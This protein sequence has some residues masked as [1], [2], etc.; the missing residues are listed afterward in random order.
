M[1]K[2]ELDNA[3]GEIPQP[4]RIM[5]PD[6]YVCENRYEFPEGMLLMKPEFKSYVEFTIRDSQAR[7][8]HVISAKLQKITEN[9]IIQ[10][11]RVLVLKVAKLPEPNLKEIGVELNV[12]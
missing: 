4:E 2:K 1:S 8:F 5:L 12:Y 3:L 7:G 9:Q 11:S 10:N 6:L